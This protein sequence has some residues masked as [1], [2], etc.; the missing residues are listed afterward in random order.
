MATY[1]DSGVE[2]GHPVESTTKKFIEGI[3]HIHVIGKRLEN[4]VD[5]EIVEGK[6]SGQTDEEQGS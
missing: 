4:I 5:K 3:D 2:I 6:K 1:I